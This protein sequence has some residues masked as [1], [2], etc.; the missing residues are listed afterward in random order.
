MN[1]KKKMLCGYSWIELMQIKDTKALTDHKGILWTGPDR[2]IDYTISIKPLFSAWL[3]DC[4]FRF[5]NHNDLDP[6]VMQSF[7]Q[8]KCYTTPPDLE[9][10][11]AIAPTI[12]HSDTYP[13]PSPIFKPPKWS[14]SFSS[15]NT[16]DT[17]PF[18][19]AE[20]Y[21]YKTI[22]Y[23]QSEE[24]KRGDR[25]HKALENACKGI[26]TADDL[27]II[28][29]NGWGKYVQ[30]IVNA[31]GE[32]YYEHEMGLDEAWKPINWFK[33]TGRCKGD[34]IIINGEKAS[35][36]DWK[37]G[38]GSDDFQLLLT[39]LFIALHFPQVKEFN[40]K[41]IKLK[42]DE[43]TGLKQPVQRKEL[44]AVYET[45]NGKLKRMLEAREQEIF[46]QRK[47]GLCKKWCATCRC[48]HSGRYRG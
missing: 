39:C 33:A 46:E 38:N 14:W 23:E 7:Q 3:K 12:L 42:T 25:V 11:Q 40:G 20:K 16:F 37:T 2:K 5:T 6:Q 29:A 30:A 18:Q 47:N 36:F 15:I 19:W 43:I 17:C 22:K 9:S 26:A 24:A 8:M 1:S 27:A 10:L 45:I 4:Q 28:Q 31:P 32:K 35:Y 21:Y 44:M 13:E 41:F 48:A 34:V